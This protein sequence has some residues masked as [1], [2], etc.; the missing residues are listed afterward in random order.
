M[1][2]NPST[3]IYMRLFKNLVCITILHVCMYVCMGHMCV[4]TCGSQMGTVDNSLLPSLN[5]LQ[6]LNSGLEA[7]APLGSQYTI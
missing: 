7:W 1:G 5:G 4:Q 3:R 6:E 2:M